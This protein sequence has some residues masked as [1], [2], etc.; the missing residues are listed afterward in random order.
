MRSCVIEGQDERRLVRLQY[1]LSGSLAAF[2][3]F[4]SGWNRLLVHFSGIA[5]QGEDNFEVQPLS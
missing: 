2:F 5:E 4:L 1:H 3:A